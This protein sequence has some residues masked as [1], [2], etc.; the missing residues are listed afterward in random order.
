MK[1][2]LEKDCLKIS[3]FPN[4]LSIVKKSKSGWIHYTFER[5]TQTIQMSE[6]D[7]MSLYHPK[8]DAFEVTKI[9]LKSSKEND[10]RS[11]KPLIDEISLRMCCLKIS[12]FAI[13]RSM[14]KNSRNGWVHNTFDRHTQIV[15]KTESDKLIYNFSEPKSLGFRNFF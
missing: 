12:S 1:F 13:L 3:R 15:R 8:I 10:Q 11:D 14:Q 5:H 9:F 2:P 4:L 7:E 6:F